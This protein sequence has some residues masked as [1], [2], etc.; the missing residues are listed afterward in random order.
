MLFSAIVLRMYVGVS[1]DGSSCIG[2][3]FSETVFMISMSATGE[4][5]W[6]SGSEAF[7][8]PRITSSAGAVAENPGAAKA[9]EELGWHAEKDIEEMCA[10]TWNWQKNNPNGYADA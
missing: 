6:V 1:S 3:D 8:V 9:E 2:A 10:D 5:S 4:N 7:G